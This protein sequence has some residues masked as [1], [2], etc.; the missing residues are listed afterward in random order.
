MMK[1]KSCAIVFMAG[2]LTA[3][4]GG[5]DGGGESNDNGGLSVPADALTITEDN[6]VATSSRAAEVAVA[7]PA[8]FSDPAVVGGVTLAPDEPLLSASEL[9]SALRQQLSAPSSEAV[10]VSGVEVNE[11]CTY[12][13]TITGDVDETDTR[14][15]GTVKFNGCKLLSRNGSGVNGSLS[16][17][18]QDKGDSNY[19]AS[20]E[21]DF[22][23]AMPGYGT[24]SYRGLSVSATGNEASGAYSIRLDVA[25]SGLTGGGFLFRTTQTFTGNDNNSPDCPT[26]GQF[27]VSGANGTQVRATANGTQVTVEYNDG[28]GNF[29]PVAQS[30]VYCTQIF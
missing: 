8:A 7:V 24:V 21:G 9:M 4:G 22:S 10:V 30:P 12:G 26:S 15:R 20:I 6:A 29:V 1:T 19:S 11:S 18:F 14:I 5:S 23:Y 17:D 2:L 25:V 3:C 16:V 28:S 27:V 13:G